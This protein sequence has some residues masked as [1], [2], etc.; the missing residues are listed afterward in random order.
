MTRSLFDI[1]TDL[2]PEEI[3]RRL[4]AAIDPYY[5]PWGRRPV[6]GRVGRRGAS[7]Y[8]R[9]R[10][11]HPFQTRLRLAYGRGTQGTLRASADIG[12]VARAMLT[13]MTVVLCGVAIAVDVETGNRTLAWLVAGAGAMGIG[14]IYAVGRGLAQGEGRWLADFVAETLDGRAMAVQ[15]TP[16]R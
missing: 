6:R 13:L 15:T 5:S 3:A 4:K 2:P 12:G 8:R 11:H 14:L 1:A 7:L 10:L 9:T 16:R